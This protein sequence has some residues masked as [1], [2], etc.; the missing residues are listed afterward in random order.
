MARICPLF[1]SS[2]GNS[3]YIGDEHVGILVD[4]GRS[5]KQIEKALDANNISISSIKAIFVTHE[6]SDHVQGLRIFASR[7]KLNVFASGGTIRALEQKGV[8][9][10]SFSA[11]AIGFEGL[12]FCG[13]HIKMFETPHD[14]S[15]SVGYIVDTV[16]YRRAVVATDIG[17]V[18]D[19]IRAA[20]SGSDV[21]LLESNHDVRMLQ[22]GVYPYYLKRRILSEIGHLSN[23]DCARELPSFVK[24]GTCKFILAHLSQEN[25]LPELAYETSV[26][27]LSYHKM[28]NGRDFQI[29]VA[30]PQNMGVLNVNF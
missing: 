5:A 14:S 24:S 12:E 10:S 27:Q 21:V 22:N 2:K 30:P 6:H 3:T 15:Q 7:Y 17:C 28:V 9:T 11:E 23:D 16:D 8:L 25:N 20:I 18:T 29:V 19:S 26:C 13:M 1:S 4:V